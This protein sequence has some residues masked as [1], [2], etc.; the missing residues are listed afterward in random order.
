MPLFLFY[1]TD[2][3]ARFE[4]VT[5]KETAEQPCP[6]CKK[7]A[8][9]TLQGQT[10]SHAFAAPKNPT[11]SGITSYDHPTA[12]MVVGRDADKKWENYGKRKKIKEKLR[13]ES[14]TRFLSRDEK[15]TYKP[16]TSESYQKRVKVGKELFRKYYED[17]LTL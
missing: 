11:N 15:D 16:M 5:T 4:R 2:C 7:P 9:K 14:G 3:N 1:C 8:P 12:E 17:S 6:L 13:A 10:F